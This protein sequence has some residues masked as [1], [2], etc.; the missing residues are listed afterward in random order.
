M[1]FYVVGGLV[2]A[3]LAVFYGCEARRTGDPVDLWC[4]ALW[5]VNVGCYLALG[6]ADWC[7]PRVRDFHQTFRVNDRLFTVSVTDDVLRVT[8]ERLPDEGDE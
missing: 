7:G 2:S 6:W 3:G 8:S 5:A 1:W 4:L